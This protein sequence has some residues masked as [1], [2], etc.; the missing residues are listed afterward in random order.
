MRIYAQAGHFG[1]FRVQLGI[2]IELRKLILNTS[3]S[4]KQDILKKCYVWR[5]EIGS[6]MNHIEDHLGQKVPLRRC[7]NSQR[8]EH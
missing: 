4:S 7:V 3:C 5:R 2:E 6:A 1:E 8:A